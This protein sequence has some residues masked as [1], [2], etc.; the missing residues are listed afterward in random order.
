MYEMLIGETPFSAMR[1][2]A[3]YMR[4]KTES[5]YYPTKLADP[6]TDFLKRLLAREPKQ[7]AGPDEI[8]AHPF[9]KGTDWSKLLAL[10]VKSPLL[11]KWKSG[12]LNP[13][14]LRHFDLSIVYGERAVDSI[15]LPPPTTGP[16]AE[17]L[18]RLAD[19]DWMCEAG[20]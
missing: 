10:Q 8:K 6:I 18:A 3:V 14:D 4:I 16:H 15:A 11:K 13:D 7:R 9:F 20:L 2:D 12:P 5:V 19:F 1:P 17:E